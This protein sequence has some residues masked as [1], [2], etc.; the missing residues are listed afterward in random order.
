METILLGTI[1][2]EKLESREITELFSIHVR[3]FYIGQF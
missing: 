1:N 2:G 3:D